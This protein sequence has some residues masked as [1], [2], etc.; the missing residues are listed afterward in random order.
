ME[1]PD[2]AITTAATAILGGI[3]MGFKTLWSRITTAADKCEKDRDQLWIAVQALEHKI[4]ECPAASC[5][6]R[7]H[8]STPPKNDPRPPLFGGYT[9]TPT[10]ST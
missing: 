8:S 9:P 5:P 6:I 10:P 3:G 7:N 2:A 1:I 4:D